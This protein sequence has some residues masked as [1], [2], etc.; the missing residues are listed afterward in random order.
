[1]PGLPIHVATKM[2]DGGRPPDLDNRSPV[3][4]TAALLKVASRCNLDCDYCYVYKHADQSWRSQPRLMSDITVEQFA[5]RL[6]EY[7]RLHKLPEFSVTFHGGEPLLFGGDKLVGAARTIRAIAGSDAS[8]TFSLQTNGTLLTDE[9]IAEFEAAEIDVSVS[10]DGPRWLHDRHRPNHGGASTYEATL[11]AIYKLQRRKSAIFTGVLAVVDPAIQPRELLEFFA[12]LSLP[13][14]DLL[15]PDS[16]HDRPP[17]G[18]DRNPLLYA[19]W[20]RE[21]FELWFRE[22]SDLPIRWFDALLGSRAGIPSPTDVMGLGSVNLIVVD[23]DGS[24]ADHDVFKITTEGRASLK[25]SLAEKS[26]DEISQHPSIRDHCFRLTVAGLHPVCQSCPVVDACGGGSVMHRW[27]PQHGLNAPSIY[28]PEL[29]SVLETATRVLRDSLPAQTDP[30]R[31]IAFD[32]GEEFL[33]ECR[34]WRAETEE[35]ANRAAEKLGRQRACDDSAAASILSEKFESARGLSLA[36]D[37]PG[38]GI[39]LETIKVQSADPRL[40]APFLDTVRVLDRDSIQVRHGLATLR[41]ATNLLWQLDINLPDAF[42]TM[43]SD[44][45]FVETTVE[46]Q[47][48]IFSFSDDSAPNVLYVSPYA[49]RTALSADDLGDS[50]L[51]E[52]LHQVLYHMERDEPMLHDHVHPHFPAPWRSGL[53]P[54]GGFLHGTF[55]FSGLSRYW[56]AL[57]QADLAGLNSEKAEDNA[58]RFRSQAQYGIQSLRQFALL[59]RRGDALLT[60]LASALSVGDEPMPAPYLTA[61]L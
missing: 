52:F 15:L 25:F 38:V 7:L 42:A 10:L 13:R 14:L 9:L 45:F 58:R 34:R 23:T 57:A 54:A 55:V 36:S 39:W 50:L 19:D 2:E 49:G 60:Q 61:L 5:R 46:S 16:T 6:H 53:R 41:S 12:S 44:V 48:Q 47:D 20:L 28:C 35:R 56:S 59:T 31:T 29:F 18:R 37:A 24:Y 3:M 43:I 21:T 1:M 32:A 26:F 17:L 27:H 22:F 30:R 51:H 4:F 33:A 11:E 8:L 40:V